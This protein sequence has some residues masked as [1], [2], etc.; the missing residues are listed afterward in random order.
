M[1]S[2]RMVAEINRTKV[3]KNKYTSDNEPLMVISEY[4]FKNVFLNFQSSCDI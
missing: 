3:K 4:T 1:A 2:P